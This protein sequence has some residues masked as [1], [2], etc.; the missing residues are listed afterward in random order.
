MLPLHDRARAPARLP[1]SMSE[2]NVC[3]TVTSHIIT[4]A[5]SSCAS[6]SERVSLK[7]VARDAT[8][9]TCLRSGKVRKVI[10]KVC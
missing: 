6:G 7:L 8:S 1:S 5:A 9:E 2:I 3:E 4:R 10:A